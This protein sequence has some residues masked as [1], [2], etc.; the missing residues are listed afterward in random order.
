MA[1]ERINLTLIIPHYENMFS[2]FYTL[3]IIKEVS[4][5]AI[6]ADVDLL[7]A[8][9]WKTH[10]ARGVLFADMLGNEDGVK[11]AIDKKIPYLILNYYDSRAKYNCAGIDNHKAAFRVADYLVK[12]GHRRLAVIT[13][14]LNAQAGIQRLEG[15]QAGLSAAKIDLEKGYIVSGDWSR[16]SGRQAMKELLSLDKLPTAVFVGGDEMAIG[17]MEAARQAGRKIPADI[18]FVG[19]DNIPQGQLAEVPLTTVE[20]PFGG[21]AS[22]GVKH[23]TQIIQGKPKQPVQILLD[24]TKLIKR[25]S[26]KELSVT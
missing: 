5:V 11:K 7:I 18:S 24:N 21:L 8:T 6:E 12:A 4:K 15:F 20:Q 26:V 16:E 22:L 1:K 10:P 25:N 23:L 9:S 17:A 19:F 2:T 3:E 14:K 13:G